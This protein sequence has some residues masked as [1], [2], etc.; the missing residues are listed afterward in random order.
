M[1]S[2]YMR[3]RM[4]FCLMRKA[5]MKWTS[6]VS[7]KELNYLYF[8]LS[9]SPAVS[10]RKAKSAKSKS[11]DIP[12]LLA[13]MNNTIHVSGFGG[14]GQSCCKPVLSKES[15]HNPL[16]EWL[17]LIA[18]RERDRETETERDRESKVD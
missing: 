5:M 16:L 3:N 17:Q 8:S 12:P 18:I 2:R 13:K 7:L 14:C 6:Q 9:L 1:M 10:R 15:V 4:M 11:D